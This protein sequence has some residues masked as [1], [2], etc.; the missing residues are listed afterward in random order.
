MKSSRKLWIFTFVVVA[1]AAYAYF[2]D[3]KKSQQE[4]SEK[5]EQ[6]EL[7]KVNPDQVNDVIIEKPDA[8]IEL[9]RDTDGWS[10][11]EPF[12]DKADNEAVDIFI[13]TA[14]SES[15]TDIVKEGDEVNWALYGLDKPKA[16]ITFVTS[17][18]EK[19]SFEVSEKKN[20]EENSFI[21]R[22]GENRVLT[23][24][25][26]WYAR[27]AKTPFDFRDKRLLRSQIAKVEG[28]LLT[29]G[30]DREELVS[31]D[32]V[33][34]NPQDKAKK[35]DQNKV[36]DILQSISDAQAQNFI[37]ERVPT[38]AEQAKYRLD[39]PAAI[40]Q[41]KTADKTWTAKV[42]QDPEHFYYVWTSEPALVLRFQPGSLAK[43]LNLRASEL[44]EK[45]VDKAVDKSAA[46]TQP[47]AK[48]QPEEKK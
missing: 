6:A 3:F 30:K 23:A 37:L 31:R 7:L 10:L 26:T 45:P 24:S 33:W 40:I 42:A 2:F 16:K 34:I 19:N 13:S 41:L 4:A 35:L 21:R 28:V 11:I 32:G 44:I 39:K 5:R 17:A 20:F 29:A 22:N 38:A 36:R 8:K 43:I 27:A 12:H 46:P 47:E 14:T 1:L 9:K 18:G 15:Y 25:G 48:T